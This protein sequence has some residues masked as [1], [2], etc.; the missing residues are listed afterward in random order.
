MEKQT[1]SDRLQIIIHERFQNCR[2]TFCFQ[3]GIRP[4][5]LGAL[6]SD[7]RMPGYDFY[8]KLLNCYPDISV[9]WII[10]GYG[11]MTIPNVNEY[12]LEIERLKNLNEFL[13]RNRF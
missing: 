9:T 5:T 6:M 8:D 13:K 3:T 4:G 10:T 11:E 1:I 12:R 7:F 2:R